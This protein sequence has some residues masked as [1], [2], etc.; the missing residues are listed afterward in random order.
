MVRV[1]NWILLLFVSIFVL[2]AFGGDQWNCYGVV[3][4][5]SAVVFVAF[6]SYMWTL[7]LAMWRDISSVFAHQ[8]INSKSW[9]NCAT[10]FATVWIFKQIKYEILNQ[11]TEKKPRS[12]KKLLKRLILG[13]GYWTETSM[14]VCNSEE[15]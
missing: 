9:W 5:S 7:L 2:V 4:R 11:I 12:W 13:N 8:T 10:T 6:A 3:F 14:N 15:A 1:F